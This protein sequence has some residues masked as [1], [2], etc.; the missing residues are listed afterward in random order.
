M[1]F[2]REMRRHLLFTRIPF[3]V[4]DFRAFSFRM[5]VSLFGARKSLRRKQKARKR[6]KPGKRSKC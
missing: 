3:R 1:L 6:A 5:I 2:H 4:C